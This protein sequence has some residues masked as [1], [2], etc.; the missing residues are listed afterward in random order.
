MAPNLGTGFGL[1]A[2]FPFY[3]RFLSSDGD[4]PIIVIS[5]ERRPNEQ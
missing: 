4:A 3:P 2:T 5:V 1:P